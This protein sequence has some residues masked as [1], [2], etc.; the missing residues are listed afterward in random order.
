MLTKKRKRD[1]ESEDDACRC[2]CKCSKNDEGPRAQHDTR[3]R[4]IFG[5]L[6]PH[7][8]DDVCFLVLEYT[9]EVEFTLE[10]DWIRFAQEQREIDLLE[11]E[12]TERRAKDNVML[13]NPFKECE[14]TEKRH[15][16][17]I[18]TMVDPAH[19]NSLSEL[20]M[21]S[22][23]QRKDGKVVAVGGL[24]ETVRNDLDVER[25]S[26]SYFHK[27]QQEFPHESYDHVIIMSSGFNGS[28]IT[29]LFLNRARLHIPDVKGFYF[30]ADGENT[31]YHGVATAK[32]MKALSVRDFT[33]KLAKGEFIWYRRFVCGLSKDGCDEGK[34]LK[35]LFFT[36]CANLHKQPTETDRNGDVI[37]WRY[38]VK[39][40]RQ[41]A[42]EDLFWACLYAAYWSR[43]IMTR[44]K[45]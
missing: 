10:M 4:E 44:D 25:C 29:S 43:Q 40:K 39:Q 36:Q 19:G 5:A 17:T 20:A 9:P 22:V 41:N 12:T 26:Q 6:S 23:Y 13:V 18:Y 14:Q 37:Q 11:E 32:D 27:L 7:L 35:E 8:Y 45:K 2:T 28:I 16:S 42:S 34:R 31:R 1:L 30:G 15:Y 3:E 38:T 21:F 33:W 24:S